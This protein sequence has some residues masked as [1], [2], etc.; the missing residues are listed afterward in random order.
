M[1]ARSHRRILAVDPTRRGFGYVV[2]EGL[3]L[4]IDWGTREA[5]T[6]DKNERSLERLQALLDRYEPDVLVVEDC[7]ARGSRRCERVQELLEEMVEL[8]ESEEIEVRPIGPREVDTTFEDLIE[9]PDNK[10]DF[11]R[12]VAELYP[13]LR[14]QLPPKRELYESETERMAIFDA[15]ALALVVLLDGESKERRPAA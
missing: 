7:E 12:V 15:A 5:R 3:G 13:P 2:F 10:H 14:P 9:H 8:A 4:L 6:E 1:I 11:A